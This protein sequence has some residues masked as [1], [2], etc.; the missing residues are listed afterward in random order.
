MKRRD[1]KEREWK[2]Q[3]GVPFQADEELLLKHL[4]ENETILAVIYED[5]GIDRHVQ[6]FQ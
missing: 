2:S 3:R 4:Q 5:P 1:K 6:F